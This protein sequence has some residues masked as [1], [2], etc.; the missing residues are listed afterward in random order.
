MLARFHSVAASA[1]QLAHEYV[2]EGQR[3]SRPE[4]L[5]AAKQLKLKTKALRTK[6]ER[7]PQ[8]PLPAIACADDGSLFI[9]ARVDQEKTLIHDP[10]LQ[11][12]IV[13]SA[14][15]LKARWSGELILIQSESSQAGE[16]SRF[17]FSS[18]LTSILRHWKFP[19]TIEKVLVHHGTTTTRCCSR[20]Y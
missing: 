2:A 10:R 11:R 13:L 14:E 17:D 20:D 6:P 9:I 18:L 16:V 4:I 12:P 8:T 15:E 7:L 3:F 1:E 19:A 5:L